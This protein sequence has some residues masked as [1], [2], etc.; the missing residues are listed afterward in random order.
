MFDETGIMRLSTTKSTL[1]NK[2]QVEVPCR[3]T[4]GPQATIME[5][6]AILWIINWPS[7]GTVHDYVH[8][9][10]SYLSTKT[11]KCD[12]YLV[13]DRYFS[14]SI[15]DGAR[16]ARAGQHASRRHKLTLQTPLPPQKVVLTVTEN[17][18]Q[19]LDIIC[20]QLVE[21]Y[22][23]EHV[24]DAHRLVI[25][26]KKVVPVEVFKGIAIYR[27]DLKIDHRSTDARVSHQWNNLHQYSM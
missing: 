16:L 4:H 21:I 7:K 24:Q 13:F 1:K 11:R 12:I 14:Y 23:A 2:L 19:L 22:Q 3:L 10:A 17:K 15:K 25:T 26:G 5:G 8:N 6:C 27:D 20:Q 9:F 18:I